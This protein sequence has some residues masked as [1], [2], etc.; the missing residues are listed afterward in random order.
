MNDEMH[1]QFFYHNKLYTE[2]CTSCYGLNID[3]QIDPIH[4]KLRTAKPG[5]E[6]TAHEVDTKIHS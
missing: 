6:R 1:P 5:N 2:K 3:N 4:R